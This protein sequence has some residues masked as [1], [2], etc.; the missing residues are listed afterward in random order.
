MRKDVLER[1]KLMKKENVKPNYSELAR[2]YDCDYRTVKKYFQ[3]DS[4]DA[5]PKKAKE[6]KLTPYMGVIDQKYDEGCTAMA[7]YYFIKKKG[8]NGSY[9]IVKRYCHQRKEEET[10]KATIRFETNPGLQAQVDWKEKLTLFTRSNKP[11]EINIFLMI[12]GFSRMKYLEL[13]LEKSQSTL[14]GCMINALDYFDGVPKE[15]LFDNMRTVVDQSRSNYQDAVI[16]DKFYQFSKDMGF[17]VYSCRAYRPQTKGKV[18]ALAKLTSRLAPYNHEFDS[19]EELSGIVRAVNDDL[20]G[21]ISQATNKIPFNLWKKEK[22]YLLPLPNQELLDGYFQRPIT[23]TVSKESMITYR[24]NKYS[25]NPKYIGKTVTLEVKEKKL[26]IFCNNILVATHEL[27]ERKFNYKLEDY[28]S[29]L[30]SDAFK[31]KKDEEINEYAK[32]ALA[33]YDAI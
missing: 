10:K 3:E 1:M 28:V 9:S 16:N 17:E 33:I 12:L 14:F 19:I 31:F 13:T 8:F 2:R 20:N 25:L 6:S 4:E 30:K 11:V 27:S 7:V 15:I 32:K 5:K 18:E 29:I 24:Y 22:E 21:E 23:R 26:K